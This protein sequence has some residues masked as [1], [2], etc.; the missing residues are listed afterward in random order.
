MGSGAFGDDVP[1][2]FGGSIIAVRWT[3]FDWTNI[4]LA[5]GQKLLSFLGKSRPGQHRFLALILHLPGQARIQVIYI[6]LG[7]RRP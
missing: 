6:Y 7:S 4:S 2:A 5:A 3:G 1:W